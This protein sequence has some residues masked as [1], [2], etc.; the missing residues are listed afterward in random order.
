MIKSDYSQI[1]LLLASHLAEERV[2]LDAMRR[3]PTCI[4]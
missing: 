4:T 3:A 2:I 1:E